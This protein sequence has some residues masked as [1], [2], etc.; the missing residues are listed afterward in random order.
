VSAIHQLVDGPLGKLVEA[1]N[2]ASSSRNYILAGLIKDLEVKL[3]TLTRQLSKLE[4]EELVCVASEDFARAAEL[5][6]EACPLRASLDACLAEASSCMLNLVVPASSPPVHGPQM[7]AHFPPVDRHS[8][9]AASG[10]SA[11]ATLATAPPMDTPVTSPATSASKPSKRVKAFQLTGQ[12][13]QITKAGGVYRDLDL[14]SVDRGTALILLETR[15]NETRDHRALAT[16]PEEENS[17]VT[18]QSDAS[19]SSD[20]EG[21]SAG[22]GD[23]QG[24]SIDPHNAN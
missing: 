11:V 2:L 5:I 7:A 4:A 20:S 22:S 19:G 14:R 1:K 3:T 9:L 15:L 17:P 13:S 10:T 18:E 21:N 6:D 16:I 24:G 8:P 12:K 23:E